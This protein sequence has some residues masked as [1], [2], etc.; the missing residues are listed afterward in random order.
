MFDDD[1]EFLEVVDDVTG[2]TYFYELEMGSDGRYVYS[3][4]EMGEPEVVQAPL[5]L[6]W[7]S[8]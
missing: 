8:F 2:D 3:G 6:D 1:Y 7:N 4:I 5:E